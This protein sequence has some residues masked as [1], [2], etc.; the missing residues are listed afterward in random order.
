MLVET[1]V[2]FGGVVSRLMRHPFTWSDE[3]ASILFLW[4]AM[5]GAVIA[6]QRGE[7][8]RLTTF[9]MWAPARVRRL[10][11]A[12][13]WIVPIVFLVWMLPFAIEH[14]VSEAIVSTPSLEWSAATKIAAIPVGVG[15]MIVLSLIRM[16]ETVRLGDFAGGGAPGGWR[17]ASCVLAWRPRR[18]RRWA[19]PTSSCSS[20]C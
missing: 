13:A 15:L 14:T 20:W 17:S 16:I 10:L 3:F 1:L 6:L 9:V 2:L 19:K 18:S 12:L 11:D 7:H 8:M 5:L 4:L